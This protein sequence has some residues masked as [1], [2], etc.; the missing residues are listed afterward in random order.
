MGLPDVAVKESKDRIKA[1]IR[2]FGYKLLEI[3]NIE[4]PSVRYKDLT[5]RSAIESSGAIKE[6]I[7]RARSMQKQRFA[8]RSMQFNA[9]ISDKEI[10]LY[11]TVDEESQKLTEMAIEKLVL[12]ARAYT[13][14]LKIARTIADIEEDEDIRSRYVAEAIQYRSLDR[15]MI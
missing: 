3:R 14:V 15:K 10:K 6:R 12:S 5:E 7:E 2:N 9:R 4:V 1:A 8:D 13:K 11:S